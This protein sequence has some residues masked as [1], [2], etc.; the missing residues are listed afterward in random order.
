M[1]LPIVVDVSFESP[2]G[3]QTPSVGADRDEL[4]RALVD[5]CS[6]AAGSGGCQIGPEGPAPA[7]ARVAVSFG[8]GDAGVR[9]VVV[10]PPASGAA[11]SA[12]SA[13]SADS[14]D[15]TFR[16]DDPLVER[17]RA[18][19]L[20][21][22][23]VVADLD[24]LDAAH[25]APGEAISSDARGG[26]FLR[27]GGRAGADDSRPWAGAELGADVVVAGHA[28]VSLSGSHDQ[29]WARDGRGISEQRTAFG[30]GV[31]WRMPIVPDRLAV[32]VRVEIA[33]DEIRATVHQP[34]TGREDAG[35]RA[36]PGLGAGAE[37]ACPLVGVV[38]VFA[39]GRLAW[40]GSD[41]TVRIQGQP[42]DIIRAWDATAVVGVD[43]HLP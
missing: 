17:Y 35:D 23:G 19:G 13:L 31:G 11:P 21:V 22:A 7:R 40:W 5:A 10:A 41:T 20:V 18:A 4:T 8:P 38:G 30:V 28:F 15:V 29:T 14:R 26:V 12:R 1:A 37:L 25:A 24:G 33:L 2:R 43:V 42:A 32:R 16:D 3:S 36:L 6:T 27:I 34:S 9:V 39:G